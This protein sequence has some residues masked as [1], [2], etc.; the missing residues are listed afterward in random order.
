VVDSI[1]PGVLT[2]ARIQRTLQCLL[3]DGVPI[4]PLPELLELMA[5]H[6]AEAAEP[7]DLADIVRRP[8]VAAVCRQARDPRGRLVVVR[9]DDAAADEIAAPGGRPP[10][11]LVADLRRA[12]R[13]AVERGA[14]PVVVVPAAVRRRFREAVARPLPD[15][16]VLAAEELVD[17]DKV[18][19]FAT[20]G[21]DAALRA[22]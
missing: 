18:E 1:V 3:R 15:L 21:G 9:V 19:V 10:A 22:A 4:R 20:V 6:A 2:V 17:E 11:R 16:V 13:P 14:R 8:L 7:A 5:D 12:T